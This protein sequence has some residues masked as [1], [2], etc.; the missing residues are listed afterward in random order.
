M[1]AD[2]DIDVR[3]TT[4]DE[5][6]IACDTM[7]AALLTGPISDED[8]VKA[9]PGWDDHLSLT[10]WDGGRCVGHAGA[11]RFDTL[12]PGGRSVPTAGVTRVGVLPTATRQGLLTRM[13][14]SLLREARAEGRSLASLRASEA[15]IYGRYGYGLAAES[16]SVRIDRARARPVA[17]T[18]AGSF[19][20][21]GRDEIL[22]V[23]PTVYE[24][25]ARRPGVISRPTYLWRRY[26]ESALVGEKAGFVAVHT[27]LDGTDDGYVH[28][29]LAWSEDTFAESHGT[30]K[31][32]DL[33][34]TTPAV[35]LALWQYLF[36]IDLVRTYDVEERPVDDALR[37]A[38]TDPRSVQVRSRWDEQWVRLLDVETALGARTY[39]PGPAVRIAVIDPLFTDNTDTFAVSDAGVAR[40]RAADADLRV[41]IASL[42][43]AYL[44]ATSWSELWSS[45]RVEAVDGSA[46][47]RADDLFVHRPGA[48]CGSFF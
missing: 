30:G 20:L 2:H 40:V 34:G 10:A 4:P 5:H 8:W 39:R 33:W 23:V 17:N 18:A 25:A 22:D 37:W 13:M 14:T 41:E 31:V 48:W 38:V 19:R 26:L 3:P 36:D 43:A 15:V 12:V 7:R 24:R 1:V 42:S 29:T 21:L 32:H 16:T 11:F 35:E 45:G 47:A 9:E 28:Y 27:G 44:G 46:V 6:R